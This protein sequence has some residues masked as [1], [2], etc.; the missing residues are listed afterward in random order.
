MHGQTFETGFIRSTLSNSRPKKLMGFYS[1][2][3]Q[4]SIESNSKTCRCKLHNRCHPTNSTDPL[5]KKNDAATENKITTLNYFITI[6]QSNLER[7]HIAPRLL[8]DSTDCDLHLIHGSL[9]AY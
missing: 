3:L 4:C 5:K 9:D 2:T 1:I 6:V 8:M 7:D